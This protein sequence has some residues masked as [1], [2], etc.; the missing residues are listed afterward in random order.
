MW[1]GWQG[2]RAGIPAECLTGAPRPIM[3]AT[4]MRVVECVGSRS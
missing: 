4:G 1:I 3:A 2:D